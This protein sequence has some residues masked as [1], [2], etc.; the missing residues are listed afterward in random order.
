MLGQFYNQKSDIKMDTG[1]IPQGSVLGSL[2][3]LWMF[4]NVLIIL[5]SIL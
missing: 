3:S 1:G 5:D 2:V 4:E